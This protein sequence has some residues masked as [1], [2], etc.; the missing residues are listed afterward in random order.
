MAKKK[1][2]KAAKTTRKT[3]AKPAAP[4][5]RATAPAAINEGPCEWQ[6]YEA[7]TGR[8]GPCFKT[9]AQAET[10]AKANDLIGV[11]RRSL[12]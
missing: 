10:W 4:K 9:I 2:K 7:S 8:V 12:G 1:K 5:A 6:P 3:T 11:R